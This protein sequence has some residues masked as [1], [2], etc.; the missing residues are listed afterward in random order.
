[1]EK[2]KVTFNDGTIL[3]AEENATSLI[4]DT[5]PDFPADL[6]D[7]TVTGATD[8]RVYKNAEVIECASVDGRFWFAFREV[9]ESERKEKKTQADLEYIA[10]MAGIDLEEV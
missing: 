3:E 8:K 5:K 10:M 7:V 4:M 9:P 6:S 2:A 1:M